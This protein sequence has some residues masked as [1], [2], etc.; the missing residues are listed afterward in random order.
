[1]KVIAG[2]DKGKT[3]PRARGRPRTGKVMV[4]G[5]MMV[6]RHTRRIRQADQ[7]R[8]RGEA[9]ADPCFERHDADPGRSADADRLQVEHWQRVAG[10]ASLARAARRWTRSS[11]RNQ[12]VESAGNRRW[13]KNAITKQRAK[14]LRQRRSRENR[15]ADCA[16]KSG[17]KARLREHYSKNVVPALQKEFGYKNVDGRAEDREGLD[18]HRSGRSHAEQPS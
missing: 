15:S 4:E 11:E 7:G 16:P 12:A 3:G 10:S 9:N 18:Q 14:K 1:M 5:V 13:Q 17:G 6:K 2:R 8:H